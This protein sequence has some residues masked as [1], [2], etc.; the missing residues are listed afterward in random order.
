M[1]RRQALAWLRAD[2]NAYA[3]L[4][5]RDAARQAVRQRLTKW[6][7]DPDLAGLRDKDALGKLSDGE[8]AAWQKLWAD[9]DAVLKRAQG[10]R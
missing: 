7:Q 10:S 2:L 4:A 8:R 1:F 9:V 3:Q 6:R 5:R